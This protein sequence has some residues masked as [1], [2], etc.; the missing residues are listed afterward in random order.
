MLGLSLEIR[1]NF[2]S[3]LALERQ[4]SPLVP[5]HEIFNKDYLSRGRLSILS[6][7]TFGLL[8]HRDSLTA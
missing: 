1:D 4:V 6:M 7:F 2:W 3:R 5:G 8:Q